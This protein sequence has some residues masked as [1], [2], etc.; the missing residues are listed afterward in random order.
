[1][2]RRNSKNQKIENISTGRATA[3]CAIADWMVPLDSARRIPL[4]STSYDF[5][6][7]SGGLKTG[8]EEELAEF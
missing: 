7:C 1:M 2:F 5:F 6:N 4:G 3:S 8:G